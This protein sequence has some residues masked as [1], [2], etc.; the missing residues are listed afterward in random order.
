MEP[1]SFTLHCNCISKG[2]DR[3]DGVVRATVEVKKEDGEIAIMGLKHGLKLFGNKNVPLGKYE[4]TYTLNKRGKFKL[5]GG[6]CFRLVSPSNIKMAVDGINCFIPADWCY[7]QETVR[8][9]R[10]IKKEA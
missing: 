6:R 1:K 3:G 2:K 10:T 4:A 5:S 7:R 9:T 8:F